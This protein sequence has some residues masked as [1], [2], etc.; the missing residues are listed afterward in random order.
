MW[1]RLVPWKPKVAGSLTSVERVLSLLQRFGFSLGQRKFI[2]CCIDVN[3]HPLI[4][5]FFEQKSRSV[6]VTIS[7]E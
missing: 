5:R 2:P 6:P 4:I 7:H 1:D 3:I